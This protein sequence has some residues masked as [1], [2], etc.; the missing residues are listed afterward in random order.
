MVSDSIDAMVNSQRVS[1]NR[2]CQTIAWSKQLDC[3]PFC[4]Q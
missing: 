2:A 1:W 4:T 3:A